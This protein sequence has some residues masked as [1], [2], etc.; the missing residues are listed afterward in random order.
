MAK[1]S[2]LLDQAKELGLKLTEKN[3]IAEIESAIEDARKTASE[4]AD[5]ES[6]G[7]ESK[8]TVAKAGKRSAKA[9]KEAEEKAAKEERKEKIASGEEEVAVKKGPKPITRSKLER[10]SKKHKEAQKLVDPEKT[11]SVKEAVELLPKLSTSKFEGSAELHIKLG[12]DPK[13][14][15]QNIRGTVILPNGTGKTKS[16][17]VFAPTDLH[18]TAKDAGADIVGEDELLEQLDKEIIDFEVLVSTPQLMAKLSKYA[19]LLGP[20]GLMPNPKTGTVSADVAKAVKEAKAGK[21]EYRVDKQGI[22]HLGVGK[23]GFESTKLAENIQ[24]VLKVIK[25]A[26]PAGLKGEYVL[27]VTVAPTMGP[28]VRLEK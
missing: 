21:V 13:H 14:A 28:G 4:A 3:T 17:A 19:R 1:K 20:K 2:E 11:Y 15:D 27:S 8:T 23:L 7:Q 12:V 9:I 26:K 10:R 25:E 18:K 22:V 16:V 6:S 5:E 24:A